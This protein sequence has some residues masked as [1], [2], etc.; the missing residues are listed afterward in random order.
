MDVHVDGN[1]HDATG[2]NRRVN[3]ILYLNPG[4]ED[5][6]GGHFGIYDNEGKNCVERIA[7]KF[8]RLVVFDTHDK[9]FHGLPDPLNFPEGK[10]RKSVI[11][12]YYTKDRR[13]GEQDRFQDPHSALWVKK[14]VADKKG[15][16]SRDFK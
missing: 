5:S 7:P 11:I 10:N 16:I 12:Y 3:A 8:N 14:G 1:Y 6:W 4:Y 15:N 9:S 2:L 13:P